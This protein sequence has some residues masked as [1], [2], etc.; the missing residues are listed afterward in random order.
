MKWRYGHTFCAH[1]I[2]WRESN[3]GPSSWRGDDANDCTTV[4]FH[5]RIIP[6][7]T[8]FGGDV[9][10]GKRRGAVNHVLAT[11]QTNA[12]LG[13]AENRSPGLLFIGQP[14]RSVNIHAKW[15]R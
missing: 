11:H 5:P 15:P 7:C 2:P 1:I 14:V 10:H 13:L 4:T 12:L 3:T 8:K 9:Y 6:I